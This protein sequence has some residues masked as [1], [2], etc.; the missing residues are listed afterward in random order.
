MKIDRTQTFY[1]ILQ[2]TLDINKVKQLTHGKLRTIALKQ[3]D[4]GLQEATTALSSKIL[5]DRHYIRRGGRSGAMNGRNLRK[6]NSSTTSRRAR[7]VDRS[8]L[9]HRTGQ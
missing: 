8:P 7:T 2:T 6:I 4:P 3:L 1:L 9:H 5:P